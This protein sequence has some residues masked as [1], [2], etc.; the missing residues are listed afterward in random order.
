MSSQ[1]GAQS[2]RRIDRMPMRAPA[3]RRAF[4]A[5]PPEERAAIYLNSMRRMMLFFTVVTVVMFVAGV[6]LAVVDLAILGSIHSAQQPSSG[7]LG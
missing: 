4:G 5:L 7:G 3:A 6:V 2:V 1:Q